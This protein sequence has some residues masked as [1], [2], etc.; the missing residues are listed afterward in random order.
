[1]NSA[2]RTQKTPIK[3]SDKFREA[4]L[5]AYPD[6]KKI[7]ELLDNNEYFLGRYLDDCSCGNAPSISPETIINK[8]ESGAIEELLEIAKKNLEE[9]NKDRLKV[10]VYKMWD[11]E[12][13]LD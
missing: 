9:V 11:K 10:K 6:N 4:V 2:F 13:F 12:C 8:I 3:Y 1:M 5:K 7:K